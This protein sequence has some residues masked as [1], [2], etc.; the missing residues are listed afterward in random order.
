MTK[1][2]NLLCLF[3][4][5]AFALAVPALVRANLEADLVF[6]MTFD[7]GKGDIVKDLS[8][9]G[10][11]GIVGGKVDWMDGKFKGAFHFD[12]VTHIAVENAAPLDALTH[13]MSVGTWVSPD[14]LG[15]WRNIVE[16]DGPAGWKM[17]FHDSHAIVWTTYFVLD[18]VSQ[19][20]VEVDE[21]THVT[22]TWDGAEAIVYINGEPDAP[23]SGG[24]VIDVQNEPSL[25]IGWR[26]S[27]EVS[28]YAGVMDDLFIF[29][30]ALSQG[31]IQDLIAGLSA[32]A[33][34]PGSKL[35][36]TWGDLKF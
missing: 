32:T 25:D 17:G 19:T 23:I 33:V 36:T 2:R 35:T 5:L 18:F 34:K 4:A 7:E 15:D 22:A 20:P 9:S 14:V 29:N 21:W 26:R 27:S 30:K 28:F 11:D 3:V 1:C 24:G 8:G 31:E 6:L 10:N 13:P 12:G 16:M